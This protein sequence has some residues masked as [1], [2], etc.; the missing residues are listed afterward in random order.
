MLDALIQAYD[1]FGPLGV[2]II[3]MFF[4]VIVTLGLAWQVWKSK[5][6][7]RQDQRDIS[8]QLADTQ[9]KLVNYVTVD[10]ALTREA[11]R[12]NTQSN[13]TSATSGTSVKESMDALLMR[14]G[15]D[16]GCKVLDPKLVCK[17]Q[18]MGISRVEM[19]ALIE[20]I[21]ETN[22]HLKATAEAVASRLEVK[23]VVD[24]SIVEETAKLA[25]ARLA[26]PSPAV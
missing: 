16:P 2:A 8:K 6:A 26:K 17:A 4:L 5:S 1:K 3:A 19:L 15:S 25:V 12:A 20:Y 22:L 24:A 13:L 9:E 14:L 21:K 18:E 7:D 10:S 23:A 11:L